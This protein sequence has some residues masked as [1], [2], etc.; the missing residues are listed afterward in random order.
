MRRVDSNLE[1]R[2]IDGGPGIPPEEREHIFER[3]VRLD[4]ANRTG[5]GP[6]LAIARRIARQHH[7]DLVCDEVPNG[8]SFT[9][10]L[11]A[12]QALQS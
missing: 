2:V 4:Q 8:A 9:L 6:G 3:F 7:G 5:T 10:G 12:D 1:A 11:P